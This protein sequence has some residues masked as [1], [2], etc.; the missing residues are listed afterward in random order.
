[1]F[2][3]ILKLNRNT[4]IGVDSHCYMTRYSSTKSYYFPSLETAFEDLYEERRRVK[5]SEKQCK[6]LEEIL[7]KIEEI[8]AE[9][10]KEIK[11]ALKNI[12][13]IKK[14]SKDKKS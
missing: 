13:E 11:K 12:P 9:T 14:E 7:V 4:W 3:T 1:M 10:T 8:N 5:L 2:K 6:S